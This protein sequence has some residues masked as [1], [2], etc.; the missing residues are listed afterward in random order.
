MTPD[1][2]ARL[3]HET[4][5]ELAPDFGYETRP[6]SAVRWESVPENNRL[7]MIATAAVVLDVM[8][9]DGEI[10]RTVRRRPT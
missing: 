7:L 6:D 2:L 9:R 10:T 5:E 3:F 4:Y 8:E 1:K